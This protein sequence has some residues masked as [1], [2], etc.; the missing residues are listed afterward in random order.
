MYVSVISFRH[1]MDESKIYK[2]LDCDGMPID[3]QLKLEPELRKYKYVVKVIL[4]T[5]RERFLF[6]NEPEAT[7]SYVKQ[8]NGKIRWVKKV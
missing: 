4:I 3:E 8:I 1:T 2:C 5:G 6:T 7:R